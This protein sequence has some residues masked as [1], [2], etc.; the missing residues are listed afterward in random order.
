MER[1]WTFCYPVVHD[2][3]SSNS[4]VTHCWY[5]CLLHTA[6]DPNGY[7]NIA[8]SQPIIVAAERNNVA[9]VELLLQSGNDYRV[10]NDDGETL[11]EVAARKG[12]HEVVQVSKMFMM[13]HCLCGGVC[14]REKIQ[15]VRDIH[16]PL[17]LRNSWIEVKCVSSSL[18][19][20]A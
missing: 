1:P 12:H 6:E 5:C 9:L 10:S 20:S 14:L 15:F 16:L 8:C 3:L 13:L 4:K 19:S 18:I 7:V 2:K 11:L 17:H